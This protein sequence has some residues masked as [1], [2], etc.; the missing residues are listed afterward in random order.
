[1]DKAPLKR[2]SDKVKM[3]ALPLTKHGVNGPLKNEP[4][5]FFLKFKAGFRK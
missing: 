1:M 4:P 5:F 2:D 3:T